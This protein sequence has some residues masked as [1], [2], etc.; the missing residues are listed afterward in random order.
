MGPFDAIYT[1]QVGD[2]RRP[3][4]TRCN[5]GRP[6]SP[7][8][9]PLGELGETYAPSFILAHSLRYVKGNSVH[10]TGSTWRIA[11]LSE[12]ARA[13]ATCNMYRTC[14]K[15][16]TCGFWDTR[17]DVQTDRQTEHTKTRWPQYLHPN[18]ERSNDIQSRCGRQIRQR[19]SD[20]RRFLLHVSVFNFIIRQLVVASKNK[21][22][23]TAKD[24]TNFAHHFSGPGSAIGSICVSVCLCFWTTFE[25]NDFWHGYL[26]YWV[27]FTIS[28]S[29]LTVKVVLWP[30]TLT[31]KLVQGRSSKFTVT[32]TPEEN[33]TKQVDAT[34]SEGVYSTSV[35]RFVRMQDYSK[36]RGLILIEFFRRNTRQKIRIVN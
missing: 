10:K 35:C 20:P 9:P 27:V 17:E 22:F 13:T 7:P 19:R 26:A 36:S 14:G 31:F 25:H 24:V 28:R 4:S 23:T 33:V 8:V 18:L 21:I 16:W 3:Q 32:G 30:T 11:L 5:R 29:S 12:E 6:T 34:S 1:G 15:N 2:G